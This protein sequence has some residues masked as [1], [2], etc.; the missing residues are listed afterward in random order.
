MMI[1]CPTAVAIVMNI[2]C[3]VAHIL[4]SLPPVY[5][6]LPAAGTLYTIYD[7]MLL[8]YDVQVHMKNSRPKK[9]LKQ[10]ATKI[11]AYEIYT[12]GL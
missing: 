3:S 4:I 9:G 10:F 12:N 11:L 7:K 6:F 2:W 1:Y 8:A 5:H